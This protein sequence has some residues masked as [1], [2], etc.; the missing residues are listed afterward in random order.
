MDL[1]RKE[2]KM[3]KGMEGQRQNGWMAGQIRD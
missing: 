2:R 3:Y 1:K